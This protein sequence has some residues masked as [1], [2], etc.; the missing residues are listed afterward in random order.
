MADIQVILLPQD[1]YYAWLGAAQGYGLKF[2]VNLTADPDSAGRLGQ[3]VTIAGAPG[4]Y[5]AQGDIQAWFHQ[6][7]PQV[8]VDYIPAASPDELGAAL[9]KRIDAG[10]RY[11]PPAPPVP[12]APVAPPAPVAPV[13]PVYPW[14]AGK[15]LVG[16]HGRT[17][18]PMQD[19]DF[20]AVRVSNVEAVKLLT[21]ARPEDI[22]RLRQIRPDVFILARLMTK[23]GAPNQFSDFF[24]GE[25]GQHMANFYARGIRYF[26]LHNEPN[27]TLE[28]WRSSWQNGGDFARF[29]LEVRDK[30]KA[31]FPEALL[32]WPGLSP[33]PGVDGVRLKDWDFVAQADAALRAADWL[34]VHCYWQSAAIMEDAAE[35]G[36][37]YRAYRQRY[38]DKL[39]FITEFSNATEPPA[40]K[41]QQY[42]SYYQSLR[43]EPGVGAA[44]SF[45][46]SASSGFESEAWRSEA[47][48][49]SEIPAAVGRR[50]AL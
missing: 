22:D 26:E 19:A 50:P 43:H 11:A 10:D 46:S 30:L 8:K 14:P 25:V 15:C 44:F 29:F 42:V 27:L 48:Q 31:R 9:Q 18:G 7:Y 33:G 6:T 5:P 3:V 13:A 45:V 28:G 38:P 20:E 36:R 1:H 39:I 23:I 47:G 34:G 24:V 37:V 49:L 41:A 4:G 32:G 21:W 12:V 16:V 2:G 40:V 35:G 17:D